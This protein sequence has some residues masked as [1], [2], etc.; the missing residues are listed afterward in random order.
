MAPNGNR[1]GGGRGG[2]RGGG[3][4]SGGRNSGGHRNS[5]SAR[6][7]INREC[8]LED[9]FPHEAG[10]GSDL[11]EESSGPMQCSCHLAMWDLGQCD[12]KRC[13]GRKLIHQKAVLELKLGQRF[14]GVCLSPMGTSSV[15][16]EDRDIITQHGLSVV[17]CSWARLEETPFHRMKAA[18]PRHGLSVVDCS[19]ARLEETPF[20]R[21]KAAHPRL[22]PWL[23]AVNPVNYGKP[24]KLSCAEAFAAALYITGHKQDAEAL[25]SRFKW[26][27][28][29]F[30]VNQE[31]L[32]QYAACST[33]VEVIAKQDAWL[34][35]AGT[36][37]ESPF[38]TDFPPSESE[39]EEEEEEEAR[40]I[41]IKMKEYSIAK[42]KNEI[43]LL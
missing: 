5:A 18:H 28:A 17:D 20:H 35:S 21:M 16:A 34:A 19:W 39:G 30:S 26:G 13:T 7:K 10:S 31:L 24:C 27:H 22:L 1:R 4:N 29:F 8:E 32:D 41:A 9:S 15:S 42:E 3:R 6:D 38:K 14:M 25:M 33:A 11:D 2:S 23:V 43:G 37:L 36:P 12:P 40:E